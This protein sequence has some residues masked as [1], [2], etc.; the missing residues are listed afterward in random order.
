MCEGGAHYDM[1][2]KVGLN[3]RIVLEV[4]AYTMTSFHN[5]NASPHLQTC[6][7]PTPLVMVLWLASIPPPLRGQ[8]K[9]S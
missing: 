8:L 5:V 3:T 2:V 9:P 6:L 1:C 4:G 7:Q